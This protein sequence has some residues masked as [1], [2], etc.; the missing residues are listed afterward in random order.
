MTQGGRKQWH[1]REERPMINVSLFILTST[2][3]EERK[4]DIIATRHLVGLED[5]CESKKKKQ[6][7]DKPSFRLLEGLQRRRTLVM[8]WR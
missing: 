8:I 5:Y 4:M 7:R 6:R 1:R 2:K 3:A